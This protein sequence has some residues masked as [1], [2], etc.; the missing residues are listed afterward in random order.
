MFDPFNGE[1]DEPEEPRPPYPTPT[2]ALLLTFGASVASLVVAVL[3]FDEI[4]VLALGV[5]EALGVGG[6]ATW[7][8]RRV[9]D[10]QAARLGLRGFSP[11][12]IPLLLCL[13]PLVFVTSELDN[14]GRDID[15]LL[16][17]AN[18][19]DALTT[20]LEGGTTSEAPGGDESTTPDEV[21]DSPS[22]F[23][24]PDDAGDDARFDAVDDAPNDADA[25]PAADAPIPV[26][27]ELPEGWALLQIAIVTLG[28]AP[29]V[30]GFLFFGVILQ[31]LVTW[32]GRR[33]GLMLTGCLYALI[34]AFGRTPADAGVA[35]SLV[36]IISL[37][38]L[39]GCLGV[40]RLATGSVLAPILVD[41][42]FK[43][44]ALMAL[45]SPELLAVPGYNIDTEAHTPLGIVLPAAGMA[46]WALWVLSGRERAEP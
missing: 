44:V 22:A 45:V 33:R 11:R 10:P 35:Q 14:W 28:I 30:E 15:S 17:S 32:L 12:L 31:G 36:A 1:D 40:T 3:L 24:A 42:G 6:V 13:V 37:V 43:A 38:T 19:E 20:T 5:G 46:V 39:G 16:P 27:D 21:E 18:V 8:A 9:P 4:D 23:D 26:I 2:S 25:D 29:V 34:H 7:A 41:T